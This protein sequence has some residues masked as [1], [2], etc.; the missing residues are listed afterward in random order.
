MEGTVIK[1]YEHPNVLV[2]WNS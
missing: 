1:C 2:T